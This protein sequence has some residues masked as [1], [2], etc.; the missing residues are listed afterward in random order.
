MTF[1][2]TVAKKKFAQKPRR[3]RSIGASYLVDVVAEDFFS[4]HWLEMDDSL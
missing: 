4:N 2:K 1:T 3:M